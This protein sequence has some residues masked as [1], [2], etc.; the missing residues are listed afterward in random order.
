MVT[1]TDP[2]GRRRCVRP[3]RPIFRPEVG[4]G[5]RHGRNCSRP[6]A[7]ATA[8]AAPPQYMHE[9]FRGMTYL[10]GPMQLIRSGAE[11]GSAAA[12]ATAAAA[13]AAAAYPEIDVEFKNVSETV[14]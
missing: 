7:A 9:E 1:L 12:V 5:P 10:T 11:R 8:A 3:P 4:F 13:T 6:A 2:G 14:Q